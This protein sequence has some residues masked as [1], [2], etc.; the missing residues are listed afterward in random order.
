MIASKAIVE[1]LKAENVKV[2]FGYPGGAIDPL[3][4][5]LAQSKIKVIISRNE[6]NAGHSAIGYARASES[7]GVCFATSGPGATNLITAIASAYMDSVPLVVFTGQV[8]SELIGRDNFQEADITGACEPF[9]KMSYLVKKAEDLPKIIKEAFYIAGTGRKGPVLIDLPV[10]IQLSEISGCKYPDSVNIAGYK[11]QSKG[12]SVQIKRALSAL[13][14]AKKPVICAGGGVISS[15]ASGELL[16]LAE[17]FDIPVVNTMMGVNAIPV[18][19]RLSMGML[20]KY[21]VDSARYALF[22]SDLLIICGARVGDRTFSDYGEYSKIKSIVHI[23]ID[24]AEIGKN[25]PVNI[26]IVGDLK[27]VLAQINEKAIPVSHSEWVNKCCEKKAEKTYVNSEN[28]VDPRL[29]I[30]EV[31]Q[32]MHEGVITADVGQNQIWTANSVSSD[33]IRFFTSGGM[34]TM[35]HSL[36]SAVGTAFAGEKNVVCVCGDG[37]FQMT[38]NELS[39]IV[40]NGLNIKIILMNNS[41]LGMIQEFE[42]NSSS[43]ASRGEIWKLKGSPDFETL[44]RAYGLKYFSVTNNDEAKSEVDLAFSKN[45][46]C[47]IECIID[48]EFPSL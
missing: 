42:N 39:T 8:S 28:F 34:G 11:P 40:S 45:E 6:Q 43:N 26:P 12:H 9:V 5:S 4:Q 36:P 46:P 16:R 19:H 1:Y 22:N 14:N 3:C 44:C 38:F 41:G 13:K 20:G 31:C 10:D 24:P 32:K 17:A 27:Q 37:G 48:P 35:G 29:V 30:N 7:V 23:D 21:G 47:L 18:S 33:N 2:V 25:I 15:G